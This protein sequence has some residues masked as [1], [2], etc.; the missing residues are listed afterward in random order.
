MY[1]RYIWGKVEEVKCVFVYVVKLDMCVFMFV[2]IVG[3]LEGWDGEF[4]GNW[5]I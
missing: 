5:E 2:F 3:F 1:V 4:G